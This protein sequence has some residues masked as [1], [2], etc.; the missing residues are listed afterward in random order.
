MHPRF[1]TSFRDERLK[2]IP[3][4]LV[5][6]IMLYMT[7]HLSNMATDEVITARDSGDI[8]TLMDRCAEFD[9]YWKAARALSLCVKVFAQPSVNG[10]EYIEGSR[11][12]G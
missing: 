4:S 3:A 10:A 9:P 7:Q 8:D 6:D 1:A 5:V 2:L 11:D 12:D